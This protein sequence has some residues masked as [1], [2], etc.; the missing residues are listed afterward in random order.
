MG[1][2]S[3]RELKRIL[4]NQLMMATLM[5]VTCR[6]VE[7]I[8]VWT[9]IIKFLSL[10][11]HLPFL[12][13]Q[14]TTNYIR[15]DPVFTWNQITKKIKNRQGLLVLIRSK[16]GIIRCHLLQSQQTHLSNSSKKTSQV[17]S[18]VRKC[19]WW[20]LPPISRE[21]LSELKL[22][23]RSVKMNPWTRSCSTLKRIIICTRLS[24]TSVS[25]RFTITD[26]QLAFTRK[27]NWVSLGE[28]RKT[29]KSTT[30]AWTWSKK[31]G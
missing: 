8:R 31:P 30:K 22:T 25:L 27:E 9:E 24:K 7:S 21:T 15:E 26:L 17:C 6:K 3:R 29:W 18:M 14:I 11:E 19:L 10:R 13:Q 1:S 28:H 2:T 23:R 5:R 12:I 16:E 20:L 4:L